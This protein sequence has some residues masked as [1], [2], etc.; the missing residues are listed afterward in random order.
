M[1]IHLDHFGNFCQFHVLHKKRHYYF[2]VLQKFPQYLTSANVVVLE[3]VYTIETK[4]N[5]FSVGERLK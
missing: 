1:L 3:S 2:I 5:V 4:G